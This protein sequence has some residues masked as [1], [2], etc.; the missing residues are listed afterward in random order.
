MLRAHVEFLASD[1]M[2]GRLCPSRSCQLTADYVRS[3]F[4]GA[5]LAT[6]VQTTEA[7][8]EIRRGDVTVR[9]STIAPDP[10]WLAFDIPARK[11]QGATGLRQLA[12]GSP[13]RRSD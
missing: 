1:S 4:I 10:K 12:P 6:Q 11:C 5:G 9:P 13:F 2:A 7:V 3:Q 8:F